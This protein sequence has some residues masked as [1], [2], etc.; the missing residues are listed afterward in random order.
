MSADN[1]TN[2]H[3]NY[4]G[5]LNPQH[6]TGAQHD[7]SPH[8]QHIGQGNDGLS[9]VMNQFSSLSLPT[10]PA[11][12]PGTNLAQV[13]AHHAYCSPQDQA[14]AYQSYHVPLHVGM[15][16]ETP[17]PFS[18]SGQFPVQGGFAP[19]PVPY[20][21]VPYTPGRVSAF[22]D[23]YPERY[24]DRSSSSDVPALEN[25]RG[26]YSTTESTPATPF[27]GS[28]SDRG[29]NSRVPVIPSSYT[30]P[31]PEQVAVPA[32]TP[33]PQP[34]DEELLALLK[35]HPAIPEAVPAVF[36]PPTHMKTIEQCLENRI[37]GNRNVYIRGLHPTT[38]DELLLQYASRFGK[39]EQSKAIIDTATGACKGYVIL[40]A[41][42]PSHANAFQLRVC[43]VRPCC[44]L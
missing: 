27:F 15:S 10:G 5:Y 11:L 18:L 9:A 40:P 41:V 29:V 1:G 38:D 12:S 32:P 37:H 36:T 3:N 30:T 28:A 25:R 26:S 8:G 13:Q 31:S 43:Q 33:K 39:V 14:V 16:P 2:R 35:E 17:Y 19:M 44:R 23:R 22:A 42:F 24:V 20:H 7:A 34:V 6:G 4:P 21:S